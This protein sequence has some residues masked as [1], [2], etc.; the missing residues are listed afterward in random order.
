MTLRCNICS[1]NVEEAQV[2]DHVNS[3]QHKDSKAR[4]GKI[5]NKGSGLS[6]AKVWAQSLG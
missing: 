3:Q 2:E 4:L 5:E 1:Q 6:V